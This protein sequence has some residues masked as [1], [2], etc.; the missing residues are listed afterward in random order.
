MIELV[1]YGTVSIVW[2]SQYCMV[3]L[4]FSMANKS[5]KLS[6]RTSCCIQEMITHYLSRKTKYSTKSQLEHHVYVQTTPK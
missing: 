1:L 5:W 4:V 2:Y 3:Q 6:S